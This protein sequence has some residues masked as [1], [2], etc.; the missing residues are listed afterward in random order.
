MGATVQ[1]LVARATWRP[2][3]VLSCVNCYSGS[4]PKCNIYTF[5]VKLLK[6]VSTG[7]KS[8]GFGY[9]HF[10]FSVPF[11]IYYVTRCK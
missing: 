6:H 3:F 10:F 2:R 5:E 1:N 8:C 7:I 9:V 4:R 11:R